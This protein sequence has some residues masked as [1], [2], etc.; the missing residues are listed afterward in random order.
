M[1]TIIIAT[2][3]PSSKDTEHSLNTLRVRVWHN[4]SVSLLTNVHVKRP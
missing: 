2:V 1:L 4:M 3:S